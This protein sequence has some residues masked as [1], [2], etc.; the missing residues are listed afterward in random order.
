MVKNEMV[1]E[2]DV[3]DLIELIQQHFEIII[4]AGIERESKLI[5]VQFEIENEVSK[6]YFDSWD[7]ILTYLLGVKDCLI[8]W[9]KIDQK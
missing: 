9:R 8:L 3:Y 6:R 1:T 4:G 7:K 5:L 2:Q